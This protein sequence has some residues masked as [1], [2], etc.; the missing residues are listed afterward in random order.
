MQLLSGSFV[1][2]KTLYFLRDLYYHL[3]KSWV[4][5]CSV[6][7]ETSYELPTVSTNV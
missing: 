6:S 4:L 2:K 7:V 5:P 3:Y 1:I